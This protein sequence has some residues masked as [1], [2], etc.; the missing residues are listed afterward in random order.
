[1]TNLMFHPEEGNKE[2]KNKI[3]AEFSFDVCAETLDL[4]FNSSQ[5]YRAQY[6]LDLKKGGQCNRFV[7]DELKKKLIDAAMQR[8]QNVMNSEQIK[9]SLEFGSAKIWICED[10]STLDQT[11]YDS[12]QIVTLEIPKW[13]EA[14]TRVLTAWKAGRQPSPPIQTRAL[15]GVQAPEGRRMKVLGAWLDDDDQEFV[16]PSKINRALHIHQYGFS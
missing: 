5:G 6:Y 8:S 15:L 7:I 16:V 10:N 13:V 11:S 14:M 9:R 3:R 4:F 1:M 2:V 12:A